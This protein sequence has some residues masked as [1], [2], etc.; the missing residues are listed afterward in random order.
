MKVVTQTRDNRDLEM[1]LAGWEI[2]RVMS[3]GDNS[4]TILTKY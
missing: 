2:P 3:P 4:R 1:Q